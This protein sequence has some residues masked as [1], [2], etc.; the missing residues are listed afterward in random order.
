MANWPYESIHDGYTIVNGS[1]SG[2]AASK[3]SCWLEYK[4]VSQSVA[5]NTS[6]IRFYVFL[7]TSGNT[8]QFDVYCNNIDSNARGA[9]S[10]SV[11]GSSVYN[12]IG[13]GFAISRIPYRNEYI[14]Q[15][16]EPYDTALGYQ[17]LMILTD[18]A[19]TE[20][21]AYGE[22]TVP[23]NSDG[24]KQITLAFTANCTYSA[25]IGTVICPRFMVQEQC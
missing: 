23:H 3:V 4:I 13:R 17:Y 7:A 14:T 9:M 1:L 11:D 8:S 18:N 24:T 12:R 19:S 20:S 21:E 25:S 10:V 5:N 15:Y 2:T 6:T 16:Q 22:C